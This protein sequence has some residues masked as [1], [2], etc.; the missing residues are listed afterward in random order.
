[1][2]RSRFCG[3]LVASVLV[4]ACGATSPGSDGSGPA[5]DETKVS[6][7]ASFYPLAFVAERI[8]GERVSVSNLTPPSVE[9]HD[10]ELTTDQVDRIEDS[11]VVVYLGGGFQPALVGALQRRQ[12][13][14]LDVSD[15]L[16]LVPGAAVELEAEEASAED[17][18]QEAEETAEEEATLIDPHFWLNPLKLAD[19]ADQ[20]KDTLIKADPEGAAT[21]ES[22]AKALR[23]DL[24]ALDG[25]FQAGLK[26]CA[27]R[28]LV[29][30]HAAF[31]YLVDRYGLTQLP[32][33]GLSPENE[34]DPGRLAELADLIKVRGITTVF[35][36]ELVPRDLADTLGRETG[37][38]TAELS[39]LEGLSEET[40][41]AGG[42]Y[43]SVMDQNLTAIRAALSC[44]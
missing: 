35:Y 33:S 15:G 4:S 25:R 14:T 28:E 39:P 20:I 2:F 36:E 27:R 29:T 18:S 32:I 1:M 7:V 41:A 42:N 3:L 31:F 30:T 22:S 9:P 38:K 21:Y 26:D 5:S 17:A 12:A 37:A 13:T 10:L 34:P 6:V 43:I 44:P 11:D 40:A 23:S 19:A 8:G 16:A 24:T